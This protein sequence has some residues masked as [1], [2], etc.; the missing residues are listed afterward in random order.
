MAACSAA[1]PAFFEIIYLFIYLFSLF[2]MNFTV[3][4]SRMLKEQAGHNTWACP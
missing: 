1:A 3:R 2:T 4:S